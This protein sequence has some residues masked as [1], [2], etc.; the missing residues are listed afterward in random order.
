MKSSPELRVRRPS[1]QENGWRAF[2][3][4]AR[5]M[6][7]YGTADLCIGCPGWEFDRAPNRPVLM[8]CVNIFGFKSL[9]PNEALFN[10]RR[11]ELMAWKSTHEE[12]DESELGR[13]GIDLLP[14]PLSMPVAVRAS[15][16][17]RQ[18]VAQRQGVEVLCELLSGGSEDTTSRHEDATEKRQTCGHDT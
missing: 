14:N 2:C 9:E 7:S 15:F 18:V 13:S 3:L 11:E 5:L 17:T 4:F 10:K 1:Q 16:D 8:S 12:F 6:C